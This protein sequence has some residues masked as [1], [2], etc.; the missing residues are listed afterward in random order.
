MLME[1]APRKKL[2]IS[3]QLLYDAFLI[4]GKPSICHGQQ[5]LAAAGVLQGKKCTACPA[6]KLNVVFS[7]ATWLEPD[8]IDRCFT[9]GNLVIGA[10]WPGQPLACDI[11]NS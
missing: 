11:L 2:V 8:P 1:F 7:G 4:P 3:A 10:A 9:D 5:I 6:V